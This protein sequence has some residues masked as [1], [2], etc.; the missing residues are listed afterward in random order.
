MISKLAKR[1][2]AYKDEKATLANHFL[3]FSLENLSL[4][5]L[6]FIATTSTVRL[7]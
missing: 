6:F 1:E 5:Y 3:S 4:A 7:R 2:R